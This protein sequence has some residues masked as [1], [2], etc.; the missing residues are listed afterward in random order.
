[1][2]ESQYDT[3]IA[4]L[5]MIVIELFQIFVLGI[6]Q[7]WIDWAVAVIFSDILIMIGDEQIKYPK[8]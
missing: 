8:H 1:M 3:A 5:A 2:V 4:L 7:N 6:H